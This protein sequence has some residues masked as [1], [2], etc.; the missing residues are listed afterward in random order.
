MVG[1]SKELRALFDEFQFKLFSSEED[2]R[3]SS[4]TL[5]KL[6]GRQA[7]TKKNKAAKGAERAEDNDI[8]MTEEKPRKRK[9]KDMEE[10]KLAEMTIR[11]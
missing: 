10:V 9:R 7:S 1:A 2:Y 5:P 8:E 6:Q 11:R 4:G 3:N